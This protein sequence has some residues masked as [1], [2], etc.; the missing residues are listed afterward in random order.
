MTL[1]FKLRSD[2]TSKVDMITPLLNKHLSYG[3]INQSKIIELA[4]NHCIIYTQH[5]YF[6]TGVITL[7]IEKDS[8]EI[9]QFGSF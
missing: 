5:E 1:F 6:V 7:F 4:T 2:E 9:K 8:I 3:L